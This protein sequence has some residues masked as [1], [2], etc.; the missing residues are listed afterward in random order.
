MY[1]T[2]SEPTPAP[3]PGDPGFWE[4][5]RANRPPNFPPN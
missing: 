2:T 4:W 3:R 5:V 1:T